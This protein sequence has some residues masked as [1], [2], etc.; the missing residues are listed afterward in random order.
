VHT[1][2]LHVSDEDIDKFLDVITLNSRN[3]I[4]SEIMSRKFR[5]NR[6]ENINPPVFNRDLDE[7]LEMM[8]NRDF[9]LMKS[10]NFFFDR[11]N[12]DLNYLVFVRNIEDERVIRN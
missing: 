8:N 9:T 6:E 10:T 11:Y 5:Y 12:A 7:Y 4:I 2:L 3:I 1:V